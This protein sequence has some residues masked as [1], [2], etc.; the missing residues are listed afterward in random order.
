MSCRIKRMQDL[1]RSA[2]SGRPNE[3][4]R[5]R[6][7]ASRPRAG[8]AEHPVQRR[9]ASFTDNRTPSLPRLRLAVVYAE[10]PPLPHRPPRT[11][12]A[13]PGPAA[14]A[15]VGAPA[16]WLVR[17]RDSAAPRSG[18]LSAPAL[19]KR[20]RFRHTCAGTGPRDA[21]C[22]AR[23]VLGTFNACEERSPATPAIAP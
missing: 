11:T 6:R 3:L 21:M 19:G 4:L 1:V 17:E 10:Q 20:A 8:W 22:Q 2:M 14:L 5:S 9:L 15:S 16:L 18:T 7:L 13:Q 23:A 12:H